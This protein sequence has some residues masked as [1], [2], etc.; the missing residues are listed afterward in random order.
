MK[1]LNKCNSFIVKYEDYRISILNLFIVSSKN[2]RPL[3]LVNFLI[4]N[5]FYLEE[6]RVV[7][8]IHLLYYIIQNWKQEVVKT[9]YK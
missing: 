6:K 5:V 9:S 1:Y 7:N 8:I 2:R 4:T 3:S